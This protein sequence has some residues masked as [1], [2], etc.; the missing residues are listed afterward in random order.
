MI[1][2]IHICTYYSHTIEFARY[3][4]GSPFYWGGGWG[5]GGYWSYTVLYKHYISLVLDNLRTNTI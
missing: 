3:I 4:S 1:N 5:V 2:Y